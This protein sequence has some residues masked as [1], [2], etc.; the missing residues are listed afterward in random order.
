VRNPQIVVV[1]RHYG[2]SI[3]TCVPADPETC[4]SGA[5][6]RSVCWVALGIGEASSSQ[7]SNVLPAGSP[8]ARR[9][10]RIVTAEGQTKSARPAD[11]WIQALGAG[12]GAALQRHGPPVVIRG[13]RTASSSSQTDRGRR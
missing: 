8:E 11:C 10:S 9:R 1:G 13:V 12:S 6:V 2:L 5:C 4:G 3:A 7:A